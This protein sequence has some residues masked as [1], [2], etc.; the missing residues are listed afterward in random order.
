MFNRLQWEELVKEFREKE[1]KLLNSKNKSYT[2]GQGEIDYLRNFREVSMFEGRTPAQ[3]GLTW[4]LKHIHGICK[5]IESGNYEWCW[6]NES[7]EQ[8]KQRISDA[9]N[10]LLLIAAC[11]E[12]EHGKKG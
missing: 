11:L 8:L 7:G 10:Y 3:T 9:R 4:F 1:D 5:A 12:D 2:G 6:E